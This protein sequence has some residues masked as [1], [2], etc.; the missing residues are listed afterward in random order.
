VEGSKSS[1][2][3]PGTDEEVTA[4]AADAGTATPADAGPKDAGVPDAAPAKKAKLKSGPTYSP[5]GTITATKSGGSKTAAF[6]QS[7]E[8]EHDPANGIY[9]NVGEIRQYI[10]WTAAE[11]PPATGAFSPKASFP[12]DTWYEDRDPAGKRYGHRSGTFAE[13]VSINHY[14]DSAGTKDCA[15]GAKYVGRDTPVGAMS[16]TG[17]WSFE[18]RAVDTVS[19]AEIGTPAK[20]AVDW[21]VP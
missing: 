17:K 10:K 1:E 14:E 8:F 6:D 21:N 7:A 18:L 19:G 11:D 4:P 16:R 5:S 9:A 2:S 12:G 13:C 15:N 20:V 3:S